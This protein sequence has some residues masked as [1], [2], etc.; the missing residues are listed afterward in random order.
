MKRRHPYCMTKEIQWKASGGRF[1]RLLI[2]YGGLILMSYFLRIGIILGI[3]IIPITLMRLLSNKLVRQV[4]VNDDRKTI[5]YRKATEEIPFDELGFSF[6]S[7][8]RNFNELTL[9]KTY[10]GTRGQTVKIYVTEIIGMKWTT[11]WK[12][13]QTESIAHELNKRQ[14]TLFKPTH[15]ELPLWER[16]I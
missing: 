3:F 5:K 13:S 11:S 2:F 12:K 16:F 7:E 14:I 15:R 10:I 6:D 4:L 9:Y 1:E 8:H